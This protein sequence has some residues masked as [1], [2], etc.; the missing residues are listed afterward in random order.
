MESPN[1]EE[2]NYYIV[3]C[4]PKTNVIKQEEEEEQEQ[5]Q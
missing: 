3:I 2:K 5:K 1:V 4:I